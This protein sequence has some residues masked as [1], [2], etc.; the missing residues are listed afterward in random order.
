MGRRW[1]PSRGPLATLGQAPVEMGSG[2]FAS[3]QD[4][5]A[6]AAIRTGSLCTRTDAARASVRRNETAH[7]AWRAAGYAPEEHWRRVKPFTD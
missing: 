3:N 4:S 7:H 6:G 5:T 1:L 2:K